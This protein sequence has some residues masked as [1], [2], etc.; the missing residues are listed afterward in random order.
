MCINWCFGNKFATVTVTA[1]I[2]SVLYIRLRWR[3]EFSC[4][5]ICLQV[6]FLCK[7]VRVST[8]EACIW[9]T[10]GRSCSSWS[11]KQ[12]QRGFVLAWAFAAPASCTRAYKWINLPAI[13]HRPLNMPSF[14]GGCSF[15]NFEMAIASMPIESSKVLKCTVDCSGVVKFFFQWR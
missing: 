2:R 12:Q 11:L 7:L 6:G 15:W 13:P 8:L 1:S 14:V 5:E 4:D 10:E 3:C 9:T